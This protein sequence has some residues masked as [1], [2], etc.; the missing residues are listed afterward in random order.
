[1]KPSQKI[2]VYSPCFSVEYCVQ[3]QVYKTQVRYFNSM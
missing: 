1:M 3:S 2:I